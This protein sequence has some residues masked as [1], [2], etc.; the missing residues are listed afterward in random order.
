MQIGLSKLPCAIYICLSV[1]ALGQTLDTPLAGR[2]LPGMSQEISVADAKDL[3]IK[4]ASGT[5]VAVL[6]QSWVPGDSSV[7]QVQD[8]HNGRLDLDVAD[9]PGD[10]L[11]IKG[12][13]YIPSTA[14]TTSTGLRLTL[15]KQSTKGMTIFADETV[16]TDQGI[17]KWVVFEVEMTI[18]KPESSD[19][20]KAKFVLFLSALKFAGP[21]YLDDLQITDSSG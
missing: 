3:G 6:D 15:R 8:H 14:K 11:K 13:Y 10:K 21:I 7:S 16:T 9:I 4:A 19:D 2:R 1:V 5:H 20:D 18:K 12:K 17:N